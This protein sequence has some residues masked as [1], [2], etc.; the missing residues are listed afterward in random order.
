MNIKDI[1]RSMHELSNIFF[2]TCRWAVGII[3][4]I[5][6]VPKIV[7]PEDF[8]RMISNYNMLPQFLLPSA[9][10]MLPWLE[11]ISGACL[12]SKK[13][14]QSAASLLSF[15]LCVFMA[16][17]IIS[18]ARGADFGCGCF[19]FLFRESQ[20]GIS[21]IVRDFVL[22]GLTLSIIFLYKE[23]NALMHEK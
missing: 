10:I 2:H 13:Y 7:Q 3:F 23:E 5:A 22:L 20:I 1:Y 18:Y 4:I 8:M 17:I 6:S 9:A 19:G 14:I 16:G 11:F 21:T 12:L 15:L